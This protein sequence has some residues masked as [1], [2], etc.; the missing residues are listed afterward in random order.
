MALFRPIFYY[1]PFT[2]FENL[3]DLVI[4][5]RLLAELR[6]R[7][8]LRVLRSGIPSDFWAGLGVRSEEVLSGTRLSFV[9]SMVLASLFSRRQAVLVTKPG[10]VNSLLG[11]LSFPKRAIKALSFFGLRL[12]GVKI[13]A[14]GISTS[15]DRFRTSFLERFSANQFFGRVIRDSASFEAAEMFRGSLYLGS[16]LAFL[17]ERWQPDEADSDS[18]KVIA[19]SFR[20]PGDLKSAQEIVRSLWSLRNNPDIRLVP[21]YQVDR[22]VEFMRWLGA[23]LDLGE[24]KKIIRRSEEYQALA[25]VVSN[26]LHVLLF[27][28]IAG[29]APLALVSESNRK[30]VALFKDLNMSDRVFEIGSQLTIGE[31]LDFEHQK[32]Q[33]TINMAR[34]KLRGA[35]DKLVKD[36]ES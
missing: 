1:H 27:S 17:L 15:S 25:G 18:V 26:R 12:A 19:V 20:D 9:W 31:V 32:G 6:E 11:H 7:G 24:P 30:I 3:G 33:H 10:D 35:I 29:G 23:E 13:C 36:L 21:T 28:W 16:D 22:D 2:Q 14:I 4:N 8:D 34:T 5:E